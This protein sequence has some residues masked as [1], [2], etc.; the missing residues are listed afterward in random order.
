M[1]NCKLCGS[2]MKIIPAGVSKKTGKAYDSFLSCPNRCK[3]PYKPSP[4]SHKGGFNEPNGY[5][6]IAEK[7]DA[8]MDFLKN[9]LGG[10]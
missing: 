9:N 7:L 8:I 6:V 3:Q 10:E 1:D 4:D 5:Q 2:Q